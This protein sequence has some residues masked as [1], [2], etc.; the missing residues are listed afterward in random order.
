MAYGS[1]EVIG[2]VAY[3]FLLV[4]SLAVIGDELAERTRIERPATPAA[5]QPA[6]TTDQLQ[7]TAVSVSSRLQ[8]DAAMW[9]F[10]SV[11]A[12]LEHEFG[13]RVVNEAL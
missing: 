10:S 4:F 8:S 2:S 11:C 7:T 12:C 13:S 3:D 5:V 1:L 6:S 9:T